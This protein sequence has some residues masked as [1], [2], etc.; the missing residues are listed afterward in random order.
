MYLWVILRSM[1]VTWLFAWAVRC[2]VFVV[3]EDNP[4]WVL[5]RQVA[6][7]VGTPAQGPQMARR[8]DCLR[9]L[10]LRSSRCACP[11]S[12][13]VVIGYVCRVWCYGRACVSLRTRRR[14]HMLGQVHDDGARWRFD[15]TCGGDERI[16]RHKGEFVFAA[17]DL[18]ECNVRT[19]Q[20][21][22]G[23]AWHGACGSG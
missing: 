16:R 6:A 15:F 19:G 18:L 20:E 4:Q 22:G 3:Q 7:I 8:E 17:E 13:G 5:D 9:R 23:Q 2:K 21:A 14:E 10:V 11:M 1:A 12:G